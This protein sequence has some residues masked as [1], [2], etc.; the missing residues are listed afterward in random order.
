MFT[1]V[2]YEVLSDADKRKKYDQFGHDAFS[3]GGGGGGPGGF[4]FSFD[5][6]FKNF[7]FPDFG[8]DNFHFSFGGNQGGHK[9]QQGGRE[10]RAGG[11]FF[12]FE[13]F[14]N[15]VCYFSSF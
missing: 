15:D 12:T 3:Q 6:I 4:P 2:A 8:D 14:F 11:G 1:Y 9:H 13:D 10:Q 5:D 7:D